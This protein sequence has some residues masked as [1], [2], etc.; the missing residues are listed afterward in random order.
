MKLVIYIFMVMLLWGGSYEIVIAHQFD[1][2][3]Y[4]RP[5]LGQEEHSELFFRGILFS[6]DLFNFAT[7]NP[8]LSR[9]DVH[10]SFVNDVLQFY[11]PKYNTYQSNY[12]LNVAVED[13]KGIALDEN[14]SYGEIVVENYE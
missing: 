6:Y 8:N 5:Q 7:G 2:G 4:G 11:R 9:L 13:R 1:V 14:S 10:I 12:E 3:Q